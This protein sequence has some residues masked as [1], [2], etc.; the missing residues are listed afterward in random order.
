[1]I[2]FKLIDVEGCGPLSWARLHCDDGSAIML[3]LAEEPENIDPEKQAIMLVLYT[4]NLPALRDQLLAQGV[5]A[6][7]IDTPPWMPRGSMMMRDP[8]GYRVNVNHWSDKEHQ[9]WLK[10]L[11]EKRS[12]GKLPTA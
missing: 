11:E 7:K 1:L 4:E 9:A 2:G 6:G 8:D 3:L 12:T 5:A 10:H